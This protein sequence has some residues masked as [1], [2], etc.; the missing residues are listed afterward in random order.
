MIQLKLKLPKPSRITQTYL[1]SRNSE[2]ATLTHLD[3]SMR[4]SVTVWQ[5]DSQ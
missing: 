5:P 3:D 4:L 1:T 2:H